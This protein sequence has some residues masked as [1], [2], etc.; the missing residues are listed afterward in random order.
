MNSVI[1]RNFDLVPNLLEYVPALQ[2]VHVSLAMPVRDSA[3]CKSRISQNHNNSMTL[4]V[5]FNG[6]E[7]NQ[8]TNT[9]VECSFPPENNHILYDCYNLCYAHHA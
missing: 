2:R 1:G 5:R 8:K 4:D 7:R 3:K 9:I 6:T